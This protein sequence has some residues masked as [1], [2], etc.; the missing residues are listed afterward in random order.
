MKRFKGI[1]K[2]V[3][4]LYKDKRFKKTHK[5]LAKLYQVKRIKQAYKHV[6]V[7]S[8][9]YLVPKI[10]QQARL[11]YDH[12]LPAWTKARSTI[13]THKL[14]SAIVLAPWLI[15]ALYVIFM[16]SPM[17][18]STAKI[19]I[20]KDLDQSPIT[21][22]AGIFGSSGPANT[23]ETFLT[24]EYLISREVMV[25]LQKS[26]DLKNHYQSGS[27]DPLSRLKRN[28]N[29][30]AHLDY[31]RNMVRATVDTKT[32][33]I[34]IEVKAFSAEKAQKLAASL[35][36]EARGFVNRVSNTVAD[37]QYAFAKQQ[38]KESKIKL[39][40][41]SKRV[42]E[43]QNSNGMFDP[44]ESAK[45]VGN[46]MAQLKSKLVEKQTDLIAFSSFMQPNSS[47]IIALRE[48]IDALKT[49]IER[50]TADLL[51]NRE[52]AGR[53]NQIM[54]DYE[55]IQL[56]LKFAQ[57][58]YRSAQQAYDAAAINVCLLY[59]SPSPRD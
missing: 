21:I 7:L 27:I 19:I 25:S 52:D 45:V 30:K 23:G 54:S 16:Q 5:R 20:E 1:Y 22:S 28:A 40:K 9:R 55:W 53:L 41:I 44:A 39:F 6:T 46:V 58:E 56:K 59:T 3:A 18:V 29:D 33:E 2:H 26:L 38:L 34:D 12:A 10:N 48:E 32:G 13:K 50:Q 8:R 14:F 17:Y 15:C 49:Q 31:Y 35:I 36:S 51:S 4:T 11:T 24:Q 47:K 37:K 42:L 43:W 57:A